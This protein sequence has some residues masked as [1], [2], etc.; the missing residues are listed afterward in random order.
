MWILPLLAC[1]GVLAS[2]WNRLR[3]DHVRAVVQLN[4][5]TSILAGRPVPTWM[6]EQ[7]EMMRSPEVLGKVVQ[8][9]GLTAAWKTSDAGALEDLRDKVICDSI[10]GTSL[11]EVKVRKVSGADP[12]EICKA[13]TKHAGERL[14]AD[15]AAETARLTAERKAVARK[16]A[17]ELVAKL[18]AAEAKF[19]AER[20]DHERGVDL[21]ARFES[22]VE[23]QADQR[24]LEQLKHQVAAEEMGGGCSFATALIEHEAPHWPGMP[25]LH[26]FEDFAIA[27]GWTFGVSVLVAIVMAYVLEMLVPRRML[28]AQ[29]APESA[30]A[31][32]QA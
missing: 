14:D 21:A 15:R 9:C 24:L 8:D 7:I 11:V 25:A 1:L 18:S 10:P 23:I 22:L 6:S 30:H 16:A 31:H 5:T 13:L 32:G 26:H 3:W 19:I 2:H 29:I 17:T 27:G 28:R 4:P 20:P 12:L